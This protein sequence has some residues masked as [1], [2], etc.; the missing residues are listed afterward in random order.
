[1]SAAQVVQ[2]D[3]GHRTAACADAA[4]LRPQH[5]KARVGEPLRRSHRNPLR[6]GR[7]TA[8][9]RSTARAPAPA[10]RSAR[11]R[12]PRCGDGATARSCALSAGAP[13][14]PA[15]RRC[16]RSNARCR[17]R[18]SPG[19]GIMSLIARAHSLRAAAR[20]R[21]RA[22]RSIDRSRTASRPPSQHR[23]ILGRER[24]V[25]PTFRPGR[26]AVGERLGAYRL[27][28]SLEDVRSRARSRPLAAISSA[29]RLRA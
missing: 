6:R 26:E 27:G 18:R 12:A 13:G 1:M 25:G 10:P 19:Q 17:C 3:A 11:R 9:A 23:L 2:V 16:R 14:V 28:G 20:A 5:A 7:A 24:H 15:A 8:A 29:I 4:R 22:G 21:S